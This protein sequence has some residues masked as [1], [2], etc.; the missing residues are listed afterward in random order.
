M[1]SDE[2]NP[3]ILDFGFAAQQSGDDGN[4]F[5]TNRVGTPDYM[6]PEMLEGIPYRGPEVDI[7]ALAIVLF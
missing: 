5:F 3:K 7:F 6:A 1:I 2:C 4:G